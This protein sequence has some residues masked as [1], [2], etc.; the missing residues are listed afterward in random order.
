MFVQSFHSNT[1]P[2]SEQIYKPQIPIAPLRKT[3]LVR[4]STSCSD[5]DLVL[6]YFSS[7][8]KNRIMYIFCILRLQKNVRQPNFSPSSFCF[9]WIRVENNR[10]RINIPDPPVHQCSGSVTFWYGSGES[11]SDQR[12]RILVFSSVTLKTQKNLFVAIYFLKVHL[13]HS[14]Q[15]EVTKQ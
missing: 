8:Q 10:P 3:W 5:P 4:L 7:W 9:C 13:H 1:T 6:F 15:I 2:N 14:S 12:I 11:I